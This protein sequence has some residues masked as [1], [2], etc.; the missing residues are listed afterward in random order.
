MFHVPESVSNIPASAD[1]S[2]WLTSGIIEFR[3]KDMRKRVVLNGQL[4]IGRHDVVT[5]KVSAHIFRGVHINVLPDELPA[6]GVICFWTSQLK[7]ADINC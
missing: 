1:G 6:F 5:S 2:R 7:I 4:D 3:V